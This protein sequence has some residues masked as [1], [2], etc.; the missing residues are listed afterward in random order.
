VIDIDSSSTAVKSTISVLLYAQV[1]LSH[2]C[3][4]N[5]FQLEKAMVAASGSASHGRCCHSEVPH[6]ISF[7]VGRTKHNEGRSLNGGAIRG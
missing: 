3:L 7:A 6:H 5:V 1:H 4:S 2:F